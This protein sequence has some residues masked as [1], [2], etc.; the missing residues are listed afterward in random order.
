VVARSKLW[1]CL[2]LPDGLVPAGVGADEL[3]LA[4]PER[5]E[6]GALGRDAAHDDAAAG[7]RDPEREV[8]A[9]ARADAVDRDV[10]AAEQERGA[11]LGL[12]L[13]RAGGA[14]DRVGRLL[15]VDDLVAPNAPAHSRCSGVLGDHGDVAG[16]R[17]LLDRE[18]REDADGAGADD[19][20]VRVGLEV[21][22]Q[23]G[24][25]GAGER[26]EQDRL[27]FGEPVGT[28]WSCERCATNIL[29]QPP[30]V[31]AQ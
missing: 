17:E 9:R 23:G 25:D 4:E 28:G 12:E 15:G 19:D 7:A 24:V 22:A 10:G 11:A 8:E 29:L 16:L 2:V 27:A 3:E 5:R 1:V 14:A 26:F 30:P 13:H 31:S 20:D 21:R 6:V 18:E